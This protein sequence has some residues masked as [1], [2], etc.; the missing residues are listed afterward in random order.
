MPL[1]LISLLSYVLFIA[2]GNGVY[3]ASR[4]YA[5]TPIAQMSTFSL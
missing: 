1:D 5:M 3:P 4:V 2:Y